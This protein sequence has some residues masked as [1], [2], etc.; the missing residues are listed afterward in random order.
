MT[1]PIAAA[2]RQGAAPQFAIGERDGIR[3]C[4]VREWLDDGIDHGF[5]GADLDLLSTQNIARFETAFL[6]AEKPLYLLHQVHG[7]QLQDSLPQVPAPAKA[8]RPQADGWFL[9]AEQNSHGAFGILTADCSPVLL[10]C[11]KTR[12][13]AALHCGWRGALGGLLPLAI[14]RFHDSGCDSADLAM[15]IGPAASIRNYEV[16]V[17]FASQFLQVGELLSG[18]LAVEPKTVRE[19]NGAFFCDVGRLLWLQ[20]RRMGLKLEAIAIHPGCTISDSE[21]FSYRRQKD[22]SGRQLS[23]ITQR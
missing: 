17:D 20:A 1:D 12:A 22:S 9:S 10:Y 13:V 15:A 19:Q 4:Y 5:L 2:Q 8:D 16:S 14:E 6:P 23:Y 3:Y 11:K 7:V 18:P 21:F